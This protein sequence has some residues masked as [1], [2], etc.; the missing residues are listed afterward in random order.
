MPIEQKIK[1]NISLAP[2]TTFKIG[3]PAKFFI[4]VNLKEELADVYEWAKE[5]KEE[6][7]VL[8]GG[9]NILVNDKGVDGLIVKIANNNITVHGERLDC[10]AGVSLSRAVS[11]AA[12][13]NL[14]GLEW[15]AGIP[16][17]TVGGAV[18]GNA[19][20]FNSSVSGII[21]TVAVFNIKKKRLE[22]F[23]NKD[24][25]FNYRESIFKN[26]FTYLV[27]QAILKMRP[28]GKDEIKKLMEKYLEF[29]NNRQP[30]LPSAGSA[31][32]NLAIVDLR[33]DN[34]NLADL[35]D[36]E[37]KIKK[38]MVG[39]GWLVE[40]AGLKGKTIGGAK[41]SLEHAN[42]I[43]NTGRATSADVAMLVS[44]IKQQVRNRFKVQLREEVQY[45]GF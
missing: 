5:K 30:K 27:W 17:A 16:G 21:E 28:A 1:Q 26:N 41:V 8:G 11:L 4:E 13:S 29:R 15:A 3:G 36:N 18:V 24:C 43:I 38:G 6:I 19:G 7:F 20:A 12:S 34:S 10:G 22:T 23:S 35:A 42:F 25:R 32:K 14:S 9:S 37:G 44:Y 2:F 31:F 33:K 45:L 39:A 40:M